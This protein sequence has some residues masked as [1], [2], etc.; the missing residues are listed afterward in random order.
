MGIYHVQNR[1]ILE[2]EKL[3]YDTIKLRSPALGKALV[4]EIQNQCFLRTGLEMSSGEV[5]Y[6]IFSGELLG[7]W[8]SRISVVPKAEEYQVNKNGRPELVDCDPYILIEASV[9]KM[10]LGHNVYGGSNDFAAVC[11]R[12][13]EVLEEQLGIELP[14]SRA[15]TVHRVDCALVY[16]LSKLACKEFFDGMQLIN[17]PRRKKG[18]AKYDMAVYFA[19]KTTTVK[20]YHKGS[21]FAVHDRSRLKHFFLSVFNHIYGKNDVENFSRVD[22]KIKALQRLADNRMRVEVEIHSDKFQYDFGKNPR[23]DEVTDAY[24]QEVYDKEV[25]KLLREGKQGM[26]TVRK[27]RVVMGRLVAIYGNALGMRLYGFWSILAQNGDELARDQFSKSTFFRCRK[28]LEDAGVSWSG[29][30][31]LVVANDGLVPNDFAPVR[32]DKRLCFLPARNREEFNV[33]REVMRLAA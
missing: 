16:R 30:D 21:E 23:V 4:D 3:A 32:T 18:S 11:E 1:S 14:H 13:V 27:S 12:F 24:L 15:W 9:H 29:T 22:K 6:E 19:G 28:Q 26:D 2:G 5:R 10:V 17:F 25:E 20:F 33:S 8:D 31:V 7:S